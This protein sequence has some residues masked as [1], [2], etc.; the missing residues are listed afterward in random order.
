MHFLMKNMNLENE[1]GGQIEMKYAYVGSVVKLFYRLSAYKEE[2]VDM[3]IDHAKN[4]S[5]LTKALGYVPLSTPLMFCGVYDDG[6]DRDLLINVGIDLMKRCHAF[7]FDSSLL[8]ISNGLN[9]EYELAKSIKSENSTFKIIDVSN[10][11]VEDRDQIHYHL[12]EYKFDSKELH[13]I[14]DVVTYLS[15]YWDI[16]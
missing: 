16:P 11:T 9:G 6:K 4:M 10:L 3:A 13:R 8:P 12:C 2:G 14:F 15:N 7:I 5:I 1:N